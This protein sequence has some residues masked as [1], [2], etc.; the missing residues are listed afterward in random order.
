[1][2]KVFFKPGSVSTNAAS[3]DLEHHL[4][5]GFH[6][7]KYFLPVKI[8]ERF[9]IFHL[10]GLRSSV[11]ISMSTSPTIFLQGYQAIIYGKLI[12]L[13]KTIGER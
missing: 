10:A 6:M 11:M 1:M 8:S 4:V 3:Q 2:L 13:S 7:V 12:N 9:V 5:A